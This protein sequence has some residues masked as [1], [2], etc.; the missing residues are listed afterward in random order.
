MEK[1][2]LILFLASILAYQPRSEKIENWEEVALHDALKLMDEW[3]C[4]EMLEETKECD[5]CHPKR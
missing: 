1:N 3:E 5:W 2:E 4:H